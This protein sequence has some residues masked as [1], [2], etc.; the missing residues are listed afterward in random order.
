MVQF[1][2]SFV[3]CWRWRCT[4]NNYRMNWQLLSW[5]QP[6]AMTTANAVNIMKPLPI[7]LLNNI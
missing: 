4:Q 3:V 7:R 6:N 2:P 5:Q 1:E